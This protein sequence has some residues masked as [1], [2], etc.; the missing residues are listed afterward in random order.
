MKI[1][2][3]VIL[4]FLVFSCTI[5]AQSRRATPRNGEG[6][7]AFLKRNK[8][9]G[10]DAYNKFLELN[11]GKFGK[12]N[13]LLKGV[14]YRLPD[15][16][17][18]SAQ[19]SKP[20]T[21]GTVAQSGKKRNFKL[22]GTKYANYTVKSN[23]LKGACFFLSSG[24]GG[25][26]PGAI[27]KV[28]GHKLHEDEYAYDI[29][30]RLARCLME[31]G[32]TVYMIIQDAK[33]GIRDDR[34]LSNSK[35]ETCMGAAIPLN[36][37]ARLKQ[38]TDKI[39]S[40]NRQSKEKYKRAVFIHLDSRRQ[41]QQLDVFFY[42]AKNSAQGKRLANTMQ[43]TF[44]DR[45]NKYQPTRGF[46]GTIST[47]NLYVLDNSTPVGIYAELGNIQNSFDQRRFLDPG[48]RQA[49]ANWMCLGFIKDYENSKKGK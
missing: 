44:N 36:Q 4:F 11:K 30:L 32:A 48:N 5:Y 26:D 37:L 14:S 18:S 42:Y 28:D 43:A 49:L 16:S 22:F 20:V 40:L 41:K 45:Y 6:I 7:H 9:T 21:T 34:Y 46:T 10:T 23:K 8:C 33:D 13:T 24:H 3:I 2:C 47:R 29:T 38:R 12:R 19:I 25:P 1:K 17:K 31:E 35:R 39:N 27:G 15:K